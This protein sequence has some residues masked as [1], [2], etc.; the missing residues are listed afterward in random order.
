MYRP[1]SRGNLSDRNNT[2]NGGNVKTS[3]NYNKLRSLGGIRA[4]QSKTQKESLSTTAITDLVASKSNPNQAL[5]KRVSAVVEADKNVGAKKM[6]PSVEAV[7]LSNNLVKKNFK[8]LQ[9]HKNI[10]QS[11]V[12]TRGV[13]LNEYSGYQESTSQQNIANSINRS[14][15]TKN[16]PSAPSIPNKYGPL[17]RPS[18]SGHSNTAVNYKN[19]SARHSHLVGLSAS[20][21]GHMLN[22]QKLMSQKEV[23]E[24][25]QSSVSMAGPPQY[26]NS[27]LSPY[28]TSGLSQIG[29][30][31]I[32]GS[33]RK[34]QIQN[35][36][37]GLILDATAQNKVPLAHNGLPLNID[38]LTRKLNQ[39]AQQQQSLEKFKKS[40]L[41]SRASSPM[42]DPTPPRF[43]D[44]PL[45][46]SSTSQ[47]KAI[48]MQS[49]TAVNK[50]QQHPKSRSANLIDP[51]YRLAMKTPDINFKDTKVK[52][53]VTHSKPAT[54]TG[55]RPPA[56]T[57]KVPSGMLQQV[58]SN[59]TLPPLSKDKRDLVSKTP[60][61]QVAKSEP[62]V[63]F[64]PDKSINAD[65]L[66]DKLVKKIVKKASHSKMLAG[67][68]SEASQA[69][70]N[71]DFINQHLDED[72]LIDEDELDENEQFSKKMLE[73]E[74]LEQESTSFKKISGKLVPNQNDT[75]LS[76]YNQIEQGTETE[77]IYHVSSDNP[78]V[79]IEVSDNA[80]NTR[81]FFCPYK[82]LRHKI[83]Y[84][85]SAFG[86]VEPRYSNT[87]FLITVTCDIL[88]FEIILDYAKEK[89][90]NAIS[91]L[92][93]LDSKTFI[94][95]LVA[96]E[97]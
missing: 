58:S 18:S 45:M 17:F 51:S 77:N 78:E 14:M 73:N 72:D 26:N 79:P 22:S 32:G 27:G 33:A 5:P 69:D 66:I 64:D 24:P 8:L 30:L 97:H 70:F 67:R 43:D 49:K 50:A 86:S 80:G 15:G 47:I 31:P 87:D 21:V 36:H 88:V 39:L 55:T 48:T 89:S 92:E 46:A 60:P 16:Q 95:V 54:A 62:A 37:P 7:L 53:N 10:R 1:N 38:L 6:S 25:K 28:N 93:N 96:S 19:N 74:K 41:S 11:L 34:T 81:K 2:K 35:I 12:A 3:L 56:Q 71:Y 13:P 29:N 57:Y 68:N 61:P 91:R 76:I 83:P 23:E 65:D 85:Q 4:R 9:N 20:N 94:A 52:V 82:L 42:V 75:A 40:S 59:T 44:N 63:K 90:N 84:F